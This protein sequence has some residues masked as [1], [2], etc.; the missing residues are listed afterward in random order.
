MSKIEDYSYR[1]QHFLLDW[2]SGS[3]AGGQRRN[4]VMCCLRLTHIPSGIT[5]TAT[6]HAFRNA[7]LKLAFQR[8]KPLL[9]DWIK[10][11]LNTQEYPKNYETIR[12]YNVVDNRVVDH[13]SGKQFSWTEV[14]RDFSK[15]LDARKQEI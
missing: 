13:A 9:T 10:S 3:G 8:L 5:V 6:E 12:T 14:E 15:V 2:Y 7:N 1:R 11:E 4:K